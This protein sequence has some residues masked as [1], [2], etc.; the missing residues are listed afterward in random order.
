M[1]GSWSVAFPAARQK[2]TSV[3]RHEMPIGQAA[4]MGNRKGC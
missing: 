2:M 3:G 4:G 1:T